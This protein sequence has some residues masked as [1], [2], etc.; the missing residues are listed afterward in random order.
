MPVQWLI[1]LPFQVL[2]IDLRVLNLLSATLMVVL[3]EHRARSGSVEAFL[4][5]GIYPLLLSPLVLPMMHSGQVWPYWL[6]IQVFAFLV[7]DRRWIWA[8]AVVALAVGTRQTALIPAASILVALVGRT[9][10][11]EWL[12]AAMAG[13]LTLAA[14]CLPFVGSHGALQMLFLTGPAR[15]LA[16]AHQ[17]GNPSNQVATSNILDWLGLAAWDSRVE[18]LLALLTLIGVRFAFRKGVGPMLAAAGVGYVMTISA[19]PYLHRY[20]YVAGLLLAGIGIAAA[21]GVEARRLRTQGMEV[22]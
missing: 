8:A 2:G 9:R 17:Q 7:L 18:M 12:G 13:A 10:L 11:S 4:R 16:N 21:G 5:L 15:A 19:N 3:V 6:A 22:A 14:T 20:Y 1:Y